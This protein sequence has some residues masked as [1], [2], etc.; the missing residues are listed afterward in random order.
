MAYAAAVMYGAVAFDAALE[1]L[2]PGDPSFAIAP[3][4][5]V[6]AIFAFLLGVGPRLP[7]P[8]L[9]SVGP[10]GVALVGT[11]VAT[12]PGAGDGAVLYALPVL[13]MS[14]FFGRR[15]AAAIVAC[16]AVAQ[17]IALLALPAAS[18][19]PGRWIDVMVVVSVVA[20]VVRAL[21]ERNESLLAQLAGEARTDALTGLLNRRGFDEQ[22]ALAL[23]HTRRAGTSLAVVTFDVDYFKRVNDEWGHE[24]GDR[25][26]VVIS[27]LITDHARVTDVAA[28]MGGE[29]FTVLLPGSDARGAEDFSERVRMALAAQDPADTPVVQMSAGVAACEAPADVETCLQRADS[30]LYEAKRAGRDRTV[31]FAEQQPTL[32]RPAKLLDVAR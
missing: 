25:V 15:G 9:A 24:T 28:R 1:G 14:F 31:A 17:T 23:A 2:L 21:Q 12:T 13:W 32:A 18:S 4:L 7:R 19:Y 26:L 5:V 29:E 11:A 8:A 22:A 16:V 27:A 30:A 20:L 10:L 6:L 3:A